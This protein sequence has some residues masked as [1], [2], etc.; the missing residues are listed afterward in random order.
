MKKLIVILVIFIA[1]MSFTSSVLADNGY[2]IKNYDIS[3]K[4]NEDSTYEVVEIIDVYFSES[5]HGIYRTI[6]TNYSNQRALI[7][8]VSINAPYSTTKTLQ[9]TTYKIGDADITLTGDRQYII[10]YT[11]DVGDDNI[12]EFDQFY[13][14]IIGT[15]WD[16]TI[17][18]V[19]FL[20]TFP[21][22]FDS[23][24]IWLSKGQYGST[25][26]AQAGFVKIGYKIEGY[27]EK[28]YPYEGLTIKVEFDEGYFIGERDNADKSRTISM[29]GWIAN[30]GLLI[31][32]Y[33]LW[34]KFGKD[35]KLYPTVQ[36]R[37]PGDMTSAEVGYVIDGIVDNKDITSL[38]IYWADKGYLTIVEEKKNKFLF[39]KI[40]HPVNG[41]LYE[42]K[43]FSAFFDLG[44]GNEVTTDDLKQK[45]Y[46]ELPG[47][48]QLVKWE[49]K[50]EKTLF[51]KKATNLSY[52]SIIAVIIPIGFLMAVMFSGILNVEFLFATGF[53][54]VFAVIFGVLIKQFIKKWF[55]LSKFGKV[56]RMIFAS[57]SLGLVTLIVLLALFMVK[58][59][60]YESIWSLTF[61]LG[62][63][64]RTMGTLIAIYILS[65]IMEKRTTYGHELLE[66]M[67]GLKDFIETAEMD[68][69]KLLS[70]KNPSYFYNI[71]PY[72]MV[73]GLDKTWAKKFEAITLEQ[74]SWYH[75]SYARGFSAM[76]FYANLNRC[77]STTATSMQMPKSTGTSMGGGGFSGGGGGGGGGGSW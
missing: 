11:Y 64:I 35:K 33:L 13:Y 76:Y 31:L 34:V 71:L 62:E 39:K 12:P 22:D 65:G 5:R 25:D 67:L 68:K 48:K 41:K 14:N 37:A 46:T 16:T 36:F 28:L 54:T 24:R 8:D 17:D 49:Y 57:I 19:D 3:I 21:S 51:S 63:T 47:L 4:I 42:Q 75:G 26:N 18:H 69:L 77:M 29:I 23:E 43:M 15:G 30:L 45:F 59:T 6:P 50:Q 58:E 72:A 74:P 60:Y 66:L 44:T 32:L 10:S 38:I 53:I 52:L 73:L 70:E 2:Y 61:I 9:D 27:S 20:L 1:I 55:V 7:S 40:M 56:S